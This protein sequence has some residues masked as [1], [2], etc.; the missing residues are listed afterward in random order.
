MADAGAMEA[1]VDSDELVSKNG[2]VAAGSR[3]LWSICYP[4]LL[5][6][7]PSFGAVPPPPWNAGDNIRHGR[8]GPISSSTGLRADRN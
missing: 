1:I 8:P 4:N 3:A 7:A 5:P 2:C 6:A